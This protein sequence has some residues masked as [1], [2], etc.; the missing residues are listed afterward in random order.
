MSLSPEDEEILAAV[1]EL[2]GG[3]G[4]DAFAVVYLRFYR[5]IVQFF[6][7]RPDLR[8]EADDLA[9]E[10][11]FR[12]W[13]RIDQ[14]AF[15]SPFCAWLFGIAQSVWKNAC[16]SR[17]AVKRGAA[18]TARR[19][20]EDEGGEPPPEPERDVFGRKAPSP[21]QVALERE[22][23]RVL[24]EAIEALPAGMRRCTELRLLGDLKY[25]EISAV[26]GIGLNSVR[27]QLFEARKRLKPVLEQYF[28]GADW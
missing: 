8:D 26:T 9:Q 2:Q 1:R 13:E 6:A 17:R 3:A 7:N 18:L 27:S 16:R 20:A 23:T 12:A 19:P 25:H 15:E 28:Q 22:R 5:P 21:E 14:F 24:R 4:P 11:L 10:T